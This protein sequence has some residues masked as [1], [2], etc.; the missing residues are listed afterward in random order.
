MKF[1]VFFVFFFILI[2]L[3]VAAAEKTEKA[4]PLPQKQTALPKKLRKRNHR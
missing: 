2:A 1:F 3:P 4:A